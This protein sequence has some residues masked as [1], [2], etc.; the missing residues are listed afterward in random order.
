MFEKSERIKKTK[1]YSQTKWSPVIKYFEGRE[2][3]IS[4]FEEF[5]ETA[6]DG[7]TAYLVYP[8]DLIMDIFTEKEKQKYRSMRIQRNV[9]SKVA[10]T[11]EKGEIPS[12][13][14]GERLKI[15]GKK[16]PITCDISVYKDNV[17]INILGKSLSGVFIRSQD[18]ADTMRSLLNI[19]HDK[20]NK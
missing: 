5:F 20:Y 2:G 11:Y 19:I 6:D 13:N 15:D 18:L 17:R 1:W 3:I 12:N 14:N 8:Q 4:S 7:G 9:K 16:Y 10:Y